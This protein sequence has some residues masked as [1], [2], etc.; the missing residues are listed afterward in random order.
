MFAR[1]VLSRIKPNLIQNTHS[2]LSPYH[3][4]QFPLFFPHRYPSL[5]A[6][7]TTPVA[8]PAQIQS[9]KESKNKE[10]KAKPASTSAYPLEVCLRLG[11]VLEML[12]L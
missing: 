2:R 10:K 9:G 7:M 8:S 11:L 3:V 4:Y 12:N 1:K 6:T 5:A